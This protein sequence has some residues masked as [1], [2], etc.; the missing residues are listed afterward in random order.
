[1]SLFIFFLVSSKIVQSEFYG[2]PIFSKEYCKEKHETIK[3]RLILGHENLRLSCPCKRLIPKWSIN[4]EQ[5]GVNWLR[6]TRDSSDK[7]ELLA[8][9]KIKPNGQFLCK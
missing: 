4:P 9:E 7:L 5:A 8:F 6:R 2:P 3:V 1:M